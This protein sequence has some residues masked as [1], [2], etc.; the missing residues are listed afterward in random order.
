[1][2]TRDAYCIVQKGEED[3][4]MLFVSRE[5]RFGMCRGQ[6]YFIFRACSRKVGLYH[7]PVGAVVSTVEANRIGVASTNAAVQKAQTNGL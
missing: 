3:I 6:S 1:M 5:S 4:C 2:V 7:K